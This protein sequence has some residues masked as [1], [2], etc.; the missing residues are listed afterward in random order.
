MGV[1]V[2]LMASGK[3]SAVRESHDG[4]RK[5]QSSRRGGVLPSFTEGTYTS[6]E[7]EPWRRGMNRRGNIRSSRNYAL[8]NDEILM[9]MMAVHG[10]GRL[11]RVRRWALAPSLNHRTQSN[12]EIGPPRLPKSTAAADDE[13]RP[14]NGAMIMRA[15]GTPQ[16]RAANI[17]AESAGWN[18][19][20]TIHD[21]AW[22]PDKAGPT[23]ITASNDRAISN[24]PKVEAR[25]R[26][27]G[28]GKNWNSASGLIVATLALC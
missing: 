8:G 19:S 26:R 4:R 18:S 1:D 10:A 5:A 12:Q 17:N 11:F 21:Q 13:Q 16:Q 9:K 20:G 23:G 22:R 15:Y 6:L 7:A 24:D 25:V 27:A 28:V 14:L 2:L 3:R